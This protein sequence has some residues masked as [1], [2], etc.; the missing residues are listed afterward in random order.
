MHVV[1]KKHALV[2]LDSISDAVGTSTAWLDY[3]WMKSDLSITGRIKDIFRICSL[4]TWRIV[5][6]ELWKTITVS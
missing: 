5:F 2:A 4:K 1:K 3:M 6:S